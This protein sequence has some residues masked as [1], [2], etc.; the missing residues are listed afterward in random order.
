MTVRRLFQ[1]F[2]ARLKF[3]KSNATESAHISTLVS[4]FALAYPEVR[5]DLVIDGRTSLRTAGDADLRS[6]VSVVYGLDTARKM[7]EVEGTDG[8][9]YIQ[10]LA[11]PPSVQRSS[12]SY[13]SFFVNR[14]Y[15]RN[16]ILAKAVETAYEGL[17]MSGRH[18]LAVL[19]IT[20]PP[21]EVDVNVHPD[22]ARG[23]ISQ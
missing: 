22:Q 8:L 11:S 6:A 15:V 5:F 16:S 3:L 21:E 13:L 7:L 19:N 4:Q 17:L 2:P 10:G 23:Q 1:S 20:V 9:L 18:P 14:R 12:R